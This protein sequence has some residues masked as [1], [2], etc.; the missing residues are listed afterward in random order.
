ME[1]LCPRVELA[2]LLPQ[3]VKGIGVVKQD[4][5]RFLGFFF[6][7]PLLVACVNFRIR[8]S[9]H[10][11]FLAPYCAFLSNFLDSTMCISLVAMR[12]SISFGMQDVRLMGRKED[13][14]EAGFLGFGSGIIGALRQTRGRR[15]RSRSS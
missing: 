10:L 1:C 9:Q 13:I 7:K 3:G 14:S 5:R 4:L 15:F 8:S 12:R 2:T 11:F 6:W